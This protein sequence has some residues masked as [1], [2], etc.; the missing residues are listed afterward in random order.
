[1]RAFDGK[2]DPSRDPDVDTTDLGRL[3]NGKDGITFLIPVDISL[4][5]DFVKNAELKLE[6]VA[7]KKRSGEIKKLGKLSCPE[8]Y[9]Y[10]GQYGVPVPTIAVKRSADSNVIEC[11]SLNQ[12]IKTCESE[13]YGI[14]NFK[15]GLFQALCSD[16]DGWMYRYVGTLPNL[17]LTLTNIN[18]EKIFEYLI[19]QSRRRLDQWSLTAQNDFL[20]LGSTLPIAAESRNSAGA[21]TPLVIP[22]YNRKIFI[23]FFLSARE[24]QDVR[25]IELGY[26]ASN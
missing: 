17:K 9:E 25:N 13:N 16:T 4:D 14:G 3:R 10:S 6:A 26:D 1:M 7:K 20:L 11:F 15:Q 8:S 23:G 2:P 18:G 21:N 5:Q 12:A 19:P 24:L 22:I